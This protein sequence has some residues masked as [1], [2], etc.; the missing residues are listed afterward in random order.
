[1]RKASA[2]ELDYAQ[3]EKLVKLAHSNTT[4][5]R[6][7]RRASI[8][9]L[10]ADGLDNHRIGE[11]LGVGRI[12]AGRWRERYAAG[13]LSWSS[14]CTGVISPSSHRRKNSAIVALAA[15]SSPSIPA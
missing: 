3:R 2:I 15:F 12:Q 7:A 6:L 13:G 11:I 4:E 8:V 10:A 1:M 5:V 14:T 9:L